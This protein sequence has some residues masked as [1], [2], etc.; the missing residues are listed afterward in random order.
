MLVLV[1]EL[2]HLLGIETRVQGRE[3]FERQCDQ[4]CVGWHCVTRT[5]LLQGL[6]QAPALKLREQDKEKR[7]STPGTSFKACRWKMPS[8]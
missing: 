5:R 7:M 8:L 4:S 6:Q 3:R 2:V 1:N